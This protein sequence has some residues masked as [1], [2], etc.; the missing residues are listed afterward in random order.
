MASVQ[1]LE[2]LRNE[3]TCSICLEFYTDP[4]STD[5][6][7]NF[8]RD[9]ILQCWGT[10]QGS[11]SCPQC[12]QQIPQRSVRPNRTLSNMVESVQRLSLNLRLEE[13]GIQCEEHE[14][15]LKLFCETDQRAICVVCAM[16]RD[17]KDHTLIPIQE[18][19]ELH[20]Q[21]LQKALETLQKQLDAMS[22][23]QREEGAAQLEVKRQAERLRKNIDAEFAK[24]HQLLTEEQRDLITKLR[25]QEE[26][27][28]GQIENNKSHISK[29]ITSINQRIT[30][31]QTR[32]TLQN[33]EFLKD[34]KSI[35][36]RSVIFPYVHLVSDIS[37]SNCVTESVISHRET[38][39][40]ES[41]EHS[42]WAEQCPEQKCNHVLGSE[43][44]TSGRHYWEVGVGNSTYW[45]VGVA[46]ESVPRKEYFT[47]GPEAG[48]WAVEPVNGKYQA[49]TSPPTPL[50][51]SVSPRVL[52]VYL[53]Y[54]G[55]QVSLY[56]ADHMSHLFTF[57]HTFTG[58]LFPYFS[59]GR[60]TDL[61][62]NP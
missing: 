6:G 26:A 56:D 46:R 32:L 42:H 29:Q 19:A 48:V 5:C 36:D 55:G 54:V 58:K 21:K 44:F 4:V 49:L 28:L 62:L 18:A 16:S 59:V 52:G 8:C 17:H 43:G 41:P 13:V 1:E 51:L 37:Q 34:I 60:N 39:V 15:K 35:I 31:I 7:H 12:R 22:H 57:T 47:H 30:E 3:A 23:C 33:T 50:P 53:D 27:I 10:G 25:Q 40:C 11:V 38:Y 14:E 45:T 20:K 9:C 24:R 61:T 2:N